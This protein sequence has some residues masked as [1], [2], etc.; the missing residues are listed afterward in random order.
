[1]ITQAD[2]LAIKAQAE[3]ELAFKMLR[4]AV[5]KYK[6]RLTAPTLW[7]SIFPWKILIVRR[8]TKSQKLVVASSS[9]SK[10]P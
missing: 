2:I 5:T 4:A 8:H 10:N 9:A 3:K 7:S 6:E 1:M